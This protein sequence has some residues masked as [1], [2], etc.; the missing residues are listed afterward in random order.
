MSLYEALL[1]GVYPKDPELQKATQDQDEI[2]TVL[3]VV[4]QRPTW[5]KYVPWLEVQ[6]A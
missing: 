4:F 3:Q 6:A 1:K 5:S 2:E